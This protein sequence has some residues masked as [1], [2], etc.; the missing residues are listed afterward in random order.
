MGGGLSWKQ[1]SDFKA[2]VRKGGLPLTLQDFVGSGNG[3]KRFSGNGQTFP[4]HQV[5]W[6]GANVRLDCGP[7]GEEYARQL[8]VPE[9]GFFRPQSYQSFLQTTVKALD[10]AV[11]LGVIGGGHQVLHIPGF[12]E[13][14]E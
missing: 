12:A 13:L 6:G 8:P 9:G 10:Q 1:A 4:E 11:G 2:N 3:R 5:G 14:L 7:D